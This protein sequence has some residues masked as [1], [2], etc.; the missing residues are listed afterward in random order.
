MSRSDAAGDG[1]LHWGSRERHPRQTQGRVDYL[2]LSITDRC[3]LRCTYCMPAEGVP[4]RAHDEILSYEELAAFARVAAGCGISKVRITGGE[5][6]VRHGCAD[7]VGMLGRTSGIHDISLTTN[8]AAAAEVRGRAARAPGCGGSTSASTAS[9][10][11]ASRA[12]RAAAGSATRWPASTPPSR[13]A[14]RRSRST[15]CCCDGVEDELDAFVDLTREREVHVRFIEFMPLD[16]R[17]RRRRPRR[18]GP[19]L[20]ARDILRR[21]MERYELVPHEGP[22]G[23]GPAQYWHVPGALGTIGFIA[24][25]S[26]HFCE[27]CNRLRLTA[28]GRLRTC[29]FS[30]E[31]VDV[32]PLIARSRR[33]ARRHRGSGVG[34]ELRPLPRG[35]AP[36]SARCPRSEGDVTRVEPSGVEPPATARRARRAWSTSAARTRPSAWRAPRR[37]SSWRP[38]PWR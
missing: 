11:S 3:N 25:V 6:L 8:G 20:P 7:F 19:L 2:R 12:S 14:S 35:S 1:P 24:G 9:T 22:Y 4:A 34:Q 13:R 23:H 5:P 30:G 18:R 26:E 15:R 10:R 36:T 29:L 38:R 16:R 21:L 31:E 17:R 37:A 28:D 32:R 27:S 33:A